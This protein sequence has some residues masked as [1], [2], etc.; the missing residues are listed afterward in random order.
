MC[1]RGLLQWVKTDRRVG[2]FLLDESTYT[3]MP[4]EQVRSLAR[5][6]RILEA[7]LQV[8]SRKGYRDASVDDI[9]AESDTSKGGVY[10][11]FPNKQA[12]F[13]ALLD[14]MAALL[15]S[16]V[17]E[18]IAAERDPVRKADIA[19]QVV[20]RTF[21]SHRT[22]A[23]LFFVDALGAGREFN[24]RMAELRAEFAALIQRHLDEAI[25]Q[26]AIPPVDTTVAARVWFGAINEVVTAWVLQ[27]P[28]G[29]LEDA[30]P[31]LRTLL[32]RSIGIQSPAYSLVSAE[33]DQSSA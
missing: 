13:L 29:R 30:Y 20:L 23:R 10:F 33:H 11:H 19:L 27:E 18:A 31:T 28:P 14:R 9:A 3:S 15:R 16:R 8:F 26:G 7:A 12:I 2:R 32:L 21:G 25:R 24:Q 5:H 1:R 6:E 17:E 22:L 4:V